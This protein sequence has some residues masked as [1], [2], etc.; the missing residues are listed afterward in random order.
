MVREGRWSIRRG[1]SLEGAALY[2]ISFLTPGI[3]LSVDAVPDAGRGGDDRGFAEAFAQCRD[4]DAHG[5]GERVGVLIAGGPRYI[6]VED[7]DVVGVDAQQLKSHVTVTGDICRYRLQT[8]A[9][10]DGVRHE[11]LVLD[12]QHAHPSMLRGAA[13]RRHIENHLRA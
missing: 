6:A 7:G 9:I 3:W 4:C 1:M 8:Q 10:A 5:V 2:K 12:D 13:Y 11:G